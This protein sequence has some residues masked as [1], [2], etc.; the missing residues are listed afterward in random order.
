MT[1]VVGV[2]YNDFTNHAASLQRAGN[3]TVGK[4][5]LLY[6]QRSFFY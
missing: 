2:P 1:T 3:Y 6:N 5:K 4:E